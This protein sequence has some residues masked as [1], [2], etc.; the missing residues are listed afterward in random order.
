MLSLLIITPSI[1][2]AQA[3]QP[4]ALLFVTSDHC[5]FCAA[6]ERDVGQLYDKTPYG[7]AAPLRRIDFADVAQQMPFLKPKIVG[8]PNFVILEA[9]Q[10]IGRIQGYSDAEMF[11]WQL[12]EYLPIDQ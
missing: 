3:E 9:N 11:Y 1:D 7:V 10:E 6:W 12:S 2:S 4:K 8:T 5:P